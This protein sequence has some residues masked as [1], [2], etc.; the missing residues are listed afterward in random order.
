MQVITRIR[1]QFTNN[2]PPSYCTTF[3]NSSL[4]H[5]LSYNSSL[6]F[7]QFAKHALGTKS[8]VCT[9]LR[10]YAFAPS[11]K[12]NV[13]TGGGATTVANVFNTPYGNNPSDATVSGNET[14]LP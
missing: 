11:A 14:S 2:P 8:L 5:P 3:F 1:Q 6:S 9:K 4:Y 12:S 7:P 13:T 10:T